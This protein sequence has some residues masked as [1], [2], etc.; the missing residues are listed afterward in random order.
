LQ[1]SSS[2]VLLVLGHLSLWIERHLLQPL[3]K[4]LGWEL[5]LLGLLASLAIPISGGWLVAGL[6]M[7]ILLFPNSRRLV[8]SDV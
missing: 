8:R 7:F 1:L 6:G 5:L 4:F 3:P 2:F